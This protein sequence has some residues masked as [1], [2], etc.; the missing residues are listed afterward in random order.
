MFFHSSTPSVYRLRETQLTSSPPLPS[1]P[2]PPQAMPELL[3]VVGRISFRDV[4]SYL[5]KVKQTP[6]KVRCVRVRGDL[7]SRCWWVMETFGIE[8]IWLPW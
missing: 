7:C 3:N 8:Y 5:E 4:W 2:S 1:R 6:T